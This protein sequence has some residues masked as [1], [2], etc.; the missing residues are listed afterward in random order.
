MSLSVSGVQCLVM[1]LALGGFWMYVFLTNLT[2]LPLLPMYDPRFHENVGHGH[3]AE[4][5]GGEAAEHV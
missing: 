5:H 3:G 4:V 1:T 2:K